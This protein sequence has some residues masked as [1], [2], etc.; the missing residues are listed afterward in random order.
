MDQSAGAAR[1]IRRV[2]ELQSDPRRA[3]HIGGMNPS[4]I[5]KPAMSG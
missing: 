1:L 3:G 2:H 5:I 4:C